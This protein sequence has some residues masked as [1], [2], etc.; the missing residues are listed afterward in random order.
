MSSF[1]PFLVLIVF[2]V[3][4]AIVRHFRDKNDA[5]YKQLK[6]SMHVKMYN[7]IYLIKKQLKESSMRNKPEK[8]PNKSDTYKNAIDVTKSPKPISY[9][10]FHREKDSFIDNMNYQLYKCKGLYI[11]T[12]RKRTVKLEAFRPDDVVVQMKKLGFIEPFEI[13]RIAFPEITPLQLSALR[14]ANIYD[15]SDVCQF[16]ASAILSKKYDHD[17]TPNPELVSYAT[18]CHIKFSYYIGKKALYDLIF[19]CLDLR[20]KIA[21]FAFCVYRYATDDRS[22]N[23]NKHPSRNLFYKFAAD[24]L[25]NE[26]FVKS[27]NRYN[28]CDLRFFGKLTVRGTI[29]YGASTDTIAY[30]TTLNFLRQ[31]FTIRN[32]ASKM[33]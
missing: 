33:I 8:R 27:M 2:F 23:L 9:S 7:D 25:S 4:L 19:N 12:N 1:I 26:S 11:Q 3:I 31:H 10:V 30:K 22:G 6:S 24:N 20:D 32:V 17:S 29:S 5:Y 18:S 28:G 16:D 14:S 13:N 21:F 15:T